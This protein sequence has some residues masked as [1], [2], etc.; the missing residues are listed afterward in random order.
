MGSYSSKTTSNE[1]LKR[2]HVK[3]QAQ[4]VPAFNGNA[5]KWQSWKR[6]ARAAIGVAGMLDVLDDAT[7]AKNH[8]ID[9]ETIF[10][11]FQVATSEGNASHLVDMHETTKDG[12]AAYQDLVEWYDGD[13][14]TTD[15]AEDIRAKLDRLTLTSKNSASEYINYFQQYTKQL[16]ELNESYTDSKTV[17]IF[18]DQIEDP[19]YNST[20]TIC[21]ENRLD[22]KECIMRMRAC[23]R[24]LLRN[25]SKSR[26]R[27]L[28]VRRN[29]LN[30]TQE[31]HNAQDGTVD[32][33]KY[34]TE[35]GYYSI[36]TEIWDQLD[37]KGKEFVRS[38]NGN[39]RKSRRK[40]ITQED[41]IL[42]NQTTSATESNNKV[43]RTPSS[44]NSE[45]N[46]DRAEKKQKTVQFH[47]DK[48]E[49]ETKEDDNPNP[50][51]EINNR[52]E[53]LSFSV[54]KNDA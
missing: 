52:R 2:S 14:L 48:P 12:Y 54:R 47:G 21:V 19:D 23:E 53:I 6:R 27:V 25:K 43:R 31:Y 38:S 9:N 35:L 16:D 34:K 7:Y 5:I 32:I 24:R 40:N 49:S 28:T 1:D 42:K 13:E 22:L 20:K 3:L 18:L 26:K 8:R 33:S 45:G 37:S 39:L 36:P 50:T 17:A 51:S 15:T 4:Q 44:T 30:D 10:H 11:L 46:P 29:L 41:S